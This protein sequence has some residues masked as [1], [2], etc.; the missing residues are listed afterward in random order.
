MLFCLFFRKIALVDHF[1]IGLQKTQRNF[2][3]EKGKKRCVWRIAHETKQKE[4][5]G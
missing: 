2:V 3:V 4:K 1:A 5:Y